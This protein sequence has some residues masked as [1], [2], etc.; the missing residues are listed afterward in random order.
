MIVIESTPGYVCKQ[1]FYVFWCIFGLNVYMKL[2][3]N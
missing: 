2:L 1:I 3:K